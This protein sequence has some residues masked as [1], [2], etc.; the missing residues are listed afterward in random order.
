MFA[1]VLVASPASA[2]DPISYTFRFVNGQTISGNAEDKVHFLPDAGGSSADNPTGMEVH[3]SCSDK[4][5]GGW[6]QKDGPV[7]GVDTAW[8]IESFFIQKGSK[9]CGTPTPPPPPPDPPAIDIEKF[10]NG[11][12]ADDPT[13]P[14]INIGETAVFSYEVTNTGDIP[15]RDLAVVDSELGPIG[16]PRTELGVGE[17]MS[18]D[19]QSE[20]VTTAGQFTMKA[21]VTGV[22]DVSTP[23]LPVGSASKGDAYRFT[24]VNGTT[25]SNVG[26]KNEFFAN[27][28]GSSVT[29]PTGMKV[30]LSCSDRF[31]GGWGQKDGPVQGVDTAWQIASFS[32]GKI[33]KGQFEQKCGDPFVTT[34]EQ[35][36]M[37]MDP[38]YFI[39]PPAPS[40]PEIDIEKYVNGRD[41]DTPPGPT[42]IAGS[43]ARFTYVVRNTG[44]VPLDRISVVDNVVGPLDCPRSELAV[45][46]AMVCDPTL[47]DAEPGLNFMEACVEG[48]NDGRQVDDCD[49]VYYTAPPRPTEP[50]I[51]IEKYV[52][53]QDADNPPG[54]SFESGLDV[55]FTYVVA[56]V[57]DVPLSQVSVVD[58]VVGPISCPRTELG[59]G[60]SMNCTPTT[61]AVEFG[62][63]SMESCV[64]GSN[65]GR[66]ATDCDPVYFKGVKDDG[67]AK[68]GDSVT[69][70]D[71]GPAAGIK[72]NLFEVGP[73]GRRGRFL[74][75]DVTDH[76]GIYGFD[77]EAD[78]YVVIFIAPDGYVLVGGNRFLERRVCLD[79]GEVDNTIDAV[80][81]KG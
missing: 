40:E 70:E 30:H 63:N 43:I 14:E 27:A 50:K 24:F 66:E 73:D 79:P 45:G 22:G 60:E 29:N 20:V 35:P 74:G 64:S 11:Q 34:S 13:G 12:D 69:F 7:Q 61:M 77:V 51:D 68:V 71:G 57:G 47:M 33:K 55:R 80:L 76:G 62:S 48:F 36:V 10:V 37:D 5:V 59:V 17:S 72:V 54:P 38:V 31:V 52:E 3:L 49:P 18:C 1:T 28:G 65:G 75:K 19:E 32:I 56:N 46:Q 23:G 81:R 15:V 42:L 44:E 9:T 67:P 4:F 41:A 21:T 25:I 16:C 78:C 53:G 39:V 26:K 8:Q 58:N 2:K 6:G